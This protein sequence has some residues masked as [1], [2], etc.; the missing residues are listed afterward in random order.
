M[1][2]FFRS[3]DSCTVLLVSVVDLSASEYIYLFRC[4]SCV[5]VCVNWFSDV[6]SAAAV[7]A[8]ATALL[9]QLVHHNTNGHID[10][11]I[12]TFKCAAGAFND[13]RPPLE[14]ILFVRVT[15]NSEFAL[16][17]IHQ[18][19]QPFSDVT[20]KQTEHET[21]INDGQYFTFWKF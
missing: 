19:A 9:W 12:S 14:S 1:R 5:Y 15:S 20:N 3:S 6:Y 2:F 18:N 17:R 7:A 8:A 10:C 16:L 21:H 11:Y 4:M 13:V